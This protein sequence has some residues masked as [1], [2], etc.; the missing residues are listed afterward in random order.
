[1]PSLLGRD[2]NATLTTTHPSLD[3][4]DAS[5][6]QDPKD[7]TGGT[8]AETAESTAVNRSTTC[9]Q[10]LLRVAEAAINPA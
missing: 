1:M 8:A 10:Q 6:G 4:A 5:L 7:V 9:I 3:A 2:G